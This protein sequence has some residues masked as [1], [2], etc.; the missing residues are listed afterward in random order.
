MIEL[1][2]YDKNANDKFIH[3]LLIHKAKL[4]RNILELKKNNKKRIK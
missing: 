1:N 4:N 3:D 2:T